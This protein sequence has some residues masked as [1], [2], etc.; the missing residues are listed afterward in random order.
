MKKI[1]LLSVAPLALLP[2]CATSC[3]IYQL[4]VD[5]QN[6][7]KVGS[8]KN[9]AIILPDN[10]NNQGSSGQN[11]PTEEVDKTKVF[12][13]N[14]LKFKLN[15]EDDFDKNEVFYANDVLENDSQKIKEKIP[16]I[17]DYWVEEIAIQGVPNISY[18]S[19]Y[20]RNIDLIKRYKLSDKE[21][22]VASE[23]QL[24]TLIKKLKGI[25]EVEP[26][27]NSDD[28]NS[29]DIA[30]K[31]LN[32][33]YLKKYLD[34][35]KSKL[36]LDFKTLNPRNAGHLKGENWPE[37]QY[38][39][40]YSTSPLEKDPNRQLIFM[41]NGIYYNGYNL[42]WK[43][44][45]EYSTDSTFSPDNKDLLFSKLFYEQD[46]AFK[47]AYSRN[48]KEGEPG[49]KS[50][51]IPKLGMDFIDYFIMGNA[52][53]VLMQSVQY[54]LLKAYL[55]YLDMMLNDIKDESKTIKEQLI[56]KYDVIR[57][58]G[59]ALLEYLKLEH[60]MG[61]TIDEQLFVFPGTDKGD[62]RDTYVWAYKQYEQ[63]ILPLT[64]YLEKASL[65]EA[66][67][68]FSNSNPNIEYYKVIWKNIEQID[69]IK[70]P[71][72]MDKDYSE[73]KLNNILDKFKPYGWK[74]K[75]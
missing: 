10:G 7:G 56:A 67:D 27:S 71:A 36:W 69:G 17:K 68:T 42:R 30:L 28:S 59:E 63:V 70:S 49:S 65:N 37:H 16:K 23:E 31:I 40:Y 9:G 54:N 22:S 72:L 25:L 50:N 46:P 13:Y 15:K 35:Y 19:R 26:T 38:D 45:R 51:P 48:P 14:G 44:D 8:G 64:K 6:R 2:L 32:K 24:K 4:F 52:K 21:Q 20:I 11:K 39:S 33:T 61:L 55:N 60:I 74:Y 12:E 1:K 73:S 3:N 43:L 41:E 57:K 29:T 53:S 75:N 5:K 34:F 18:V 58:F 66:L 62:F 47:V